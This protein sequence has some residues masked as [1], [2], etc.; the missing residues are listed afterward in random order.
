MFEQPNPAGPKKIEFHISVQDVA[1]AV[2]GSGPGQPQDED[3]SKGSAFILCPECSVQLTKSAMK[4][5]Q[6]M[7]RKYKEI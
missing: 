7:L 6:F 4:K 1:A 3:K 2:E 5:V